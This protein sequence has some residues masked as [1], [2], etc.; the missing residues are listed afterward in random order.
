MYI[1]VC[2]TIALWVKIV[3]NGSVGKINIFH[4]LIIS[5]R[6]N[7]E[8]ESLNANILTYIPTCF[9]KEEQLRTSDNILVPIMIIFYFNFYMYYLSSFFL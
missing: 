6:F 2:V 5:D 4:R 3:N 8:K 7:S 9:E 1:S